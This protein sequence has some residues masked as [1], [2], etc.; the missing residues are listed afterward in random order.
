MYDLF[1]YE[2]LV[3]FTSL[4]FYDFEEIEELVCDFCEK[5]ISKPVKNCMKDCNHIFCSHCICELEDNKC[6]KCDTGLEYLVCDHDRGV[7]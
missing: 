7:I 5:I 4:E 6:F 2:N 1:N 3:P